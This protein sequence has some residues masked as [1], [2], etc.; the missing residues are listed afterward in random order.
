MGEVSYQAHQG[1][2]DGYS[3]DEGCSGRDEVGHRH[4][5]SSSEYTYLLSADLFLI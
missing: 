5:S 1:D 4:L 2:E 3:Q